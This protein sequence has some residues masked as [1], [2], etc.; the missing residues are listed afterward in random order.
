MKKGKVIGIAGNARS[1]KDTTG[2][3]AK[4]ILLEE[5][6]EVSKICGFA[7][8]LKKDLD[9]LCW[10]QFG[11]SAFTSKDQQKT[12]IRPLLVAYGTHVCRAHDERHW[13][14]RMDPTIKF[15]TDLG[16]NVIITDV[17]Y[18]NEAEWIQEKWKGKCI[19]VHRIG[20]KPA[21]HEEKINSPILKSRADTIINWKTLGG[22]DFKAKRKVKAALKRLE[23][24]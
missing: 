7:D 1:G 12:L 24:I 4:G 6:E 11:F 14:K 9:K 19:F 13:I 5:K 23:V 18:E 17:R 16:R 15:F 3:M 10:D 22:D 20:N 2:V 8:L 21:N